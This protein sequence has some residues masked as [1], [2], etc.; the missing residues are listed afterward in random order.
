MYDKENFFIATMSLNK[1]FDDLMELIL[2]ELE[3][4]FDHLYTVYCSYT[5]STFNTRRK[6][7]IKFSV[8]PYDDQEYFTT[9][10]LKEMDWEKIKNIYVN[11]DYGENHWFE[12]KIMGFIFEKGVKVKILKSIERKL[13]QYGRF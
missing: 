7:S 9:C 8:E 2:D 11:Y 12:C 4:D 1:T 5:G 6:N 10:K 3:W 13:D